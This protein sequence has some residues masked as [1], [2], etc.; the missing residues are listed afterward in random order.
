MTTTL[1][2]ARTAAN[3]PPGDLY[4]GLAI[5]WP[6][7]RLQMVSLTIAGRKFFSPVQQNEQ[8]TADLPAEVLELRSKFEAASPALYFRARTKLTELAAGLIAHL[9]RQLRGD[10]LAIGACEAGLWQYAL[11]EPV[12]YLSLID[13]A[14]LAEA[15]GITLIDDFPARDLAQ[16]GSGRP[17]DALPLWMLARDSKK[18]RVAIHLEPQIRLTY[19]PASHDASGAERIV[20]CPLPEAPGGTPEETAGR[21][22][23]AIWKQIP[24]APPLQQVIY[25]PGGSTD[26]RLIAALRRKL[27]M[28]EEVDPAALQ[29]PLETLPAA[30]AAL[31]AHLHLHQHTAGGTLLTGAMA[32]RVLGTLTPGSPAN[33]Q[34]VLSQIASHQPRRMTL[35][36]AI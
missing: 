28:L 9:P 34:R 19:L 27:S 8:V 14:L 36:A 13:A 24:K 6:R 11:G 33:W 29:L 4:L 32:P 20:A 31:L 16:G 18:P 30:A 5:D 26:A 35:R 21:V 7:S 25:L 3:R 1:D 12:G 23:E 2:Q 17:L 15:T 10:P 22:A